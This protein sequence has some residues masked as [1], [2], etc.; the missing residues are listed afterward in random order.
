MYRG[1]RKRGWNEEMRIAQGLMALYYRRVFSMVYYTT[2]R[3]ADIEPALGRRTDQRLS[4]PML[5]EE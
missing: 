3:Q 4:D 1:L 2:M 5:W